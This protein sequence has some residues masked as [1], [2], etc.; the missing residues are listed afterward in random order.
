MRAFKK[1][2]STSFIPVNASGAVDATNDLVVGGHDYFGACTHYGQACEEILQRTGRENP[3]MLLLYA[4]TIYLAV[5]ST[6]TSNPLV[7]RQSVILLEQAK[8][9]L[10]VAHHKARTEKLAQFSLVLFD[11]V[12]QLQLQLKQMAIQLENVQLSEAEFEYIIAEKAVL[13]ADG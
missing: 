2:Y 13:V 3:C 5:M 1:A 8:C 12:E 10:S 9:L 4:R 6:E 7:V 11:K